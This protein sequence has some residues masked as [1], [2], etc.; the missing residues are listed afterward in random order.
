[1][2][3]WGPGV[4][5]RA[6]ERREEKILT[7]FWCCCRRR[8][9]EGTMGSLK[10]QKKA[11]LDEPDATG[12]DGSLRSPAAFARCSR[13]LAAAGAARSSDWLARSPATDSGDYWPL[14]CCPQATRDARAACCAWTA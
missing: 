10:K 5:G 11:D 4:V 9:S 2:F 12:V 6:A 8:C 13:Y 7:A 1:M 3:R 14:R